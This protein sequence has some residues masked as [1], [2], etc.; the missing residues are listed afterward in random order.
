MTNT[1]TAFSFLVAVAI[2]AAAPF[3]AHALDTTSTGTGAGAITTQESGT[4]AG[5]VTT[6]GTTSTGTG[7]GSVSTPGTESTGTG[8]GSVTTPG[9]TSTGTG[10]G[11]VTTPGTT[12]TGTGAGSITTP[13]TTSTGTG[14]GSITTPGTVSTGTGAGNTATPSTPPNSNGN[15]SGSVSNGNVST[16]SSSSGSNQS[17]SSGGSSGGS[18]NL[19]VLVSTAQCAYL[20]SYVQTG[21][22]NNTAD[23]IKLQS[24]LKNTEGMNVI[25]TGVYDAQT[26]AA[27]NAFQVKYTAD[28]LTPWGVT[29]PTSQVYYTTSKKIN[30]IFC[31][32]TFALT[33]AQLA[34]I[35]RYRTNLQNGTTITG[36]VGTTGSTVG[37]PTGSSIDS[38]ATSTSDSTQVGAVAKTPLFTK[39]WNFIKH[40]FGR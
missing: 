2:L 27:V 22:V 28:V 34:E 36:T 13:G 4:G 35:T 21:K 33:P 30:E 25:Q 3:S 1:K 32:K 5:S 29:N 23:V 14:A 12:S 40:I 24:F 6:P 31:K 16:G 37:N 18:V 26:I 10:A 8:A 11:T 19:P 20:G 9:T 38:T 15:G 17:V 39:I 7:A